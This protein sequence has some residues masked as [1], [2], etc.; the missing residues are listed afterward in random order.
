MTCLPSQQQTSP[1]P[2]NQAGSA[3]FNLTRCLLKGPAVGRGLSAP[4][5]SR[6]AETTERPAEGRGIGSGCFP[7]P[8]AE[9]LGDFSEDIL[10]ARG[11]GLQ[12]AAGPPSPLSSSSHRLRAVGVHGD[13]GSYGSMVSPLNFSGPGEP[14]VKWLVPRHKR[15]G[16]HQRQGRPPPP[17][18]LAAT[19]WEE[20][21]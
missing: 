1:L 2:S 11:S 21:R 5:T 12:G 15:P 16:H 4:G 6:A 9:F 20:M 8:L 14:P 10:A 3:A 19:Q 7:Y 18:A 17:A 13:P